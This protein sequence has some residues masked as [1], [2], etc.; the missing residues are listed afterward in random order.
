VDIYTI[1]HAGLIPQKRGNI[2]R[3]KKLRSSMQ[4]IKQLRFVSR[5]GWLCYSLKLTKFLGGRAAPYSP[6]TVAPLVDTSVTCFTTVISTISITFRRS[7]ITK[8]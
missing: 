3:L 4:V 2:C 6:T 7:N 8:K 1:L 5:F